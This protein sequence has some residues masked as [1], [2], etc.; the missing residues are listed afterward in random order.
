SLTA[1]HEGQNI[2]IKVQDT[3]VGI[4]PELLPRVFDLFTQGDRTLARSQGGLGIGLTLVQ[5]LAE[6]HGGRVTSTS[7]GLGR[8]SE[9]AVRL[10]ALEEQAARNPDLRGDLPRVVH[11]GSRVLVVDDNV[12]TAN[13]LSRLLKLLGHDVR[14]A[15]D[16]PAALEAARSY[17]PE[18]VLMDIGLS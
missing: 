11:Q 16:G 6:M 8:G 3:G 4:T 18:V 2:V 15:H 1:R 14:V 7:G 9:F 5:Q 13:G 12:D 10:P 17:C